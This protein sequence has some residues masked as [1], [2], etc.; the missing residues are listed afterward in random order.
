MNQIPFDASAPSEQARLAFDHLYR[1]V[2]AEREALDRMNQHFN[3]LTQRFPKRVMEQEKAQEL[4]LFARV[5]G[6]RGWGLFQDR[7][8]LKRHL[9]FDAMSD[10]YLQKKRFAERNIAFYV[11]RMGVMAQESIQ[12]TS[13]VENLWRRLEL[14]KRLRPLWEYTANDHLRRDAFAAY[15]RAFR[16]LPPSFQRRAFSDQMT[17]YLFRTA[18]ELKEQVWFHIEAIRLLVDIDTQAF[19]QVAKRWFSD[20]QQPDALF[21][22]ARITQTWGNFLNIYPELQD[23]APMILADPSPFVRQTFARAIIKGPAA[24][25]QPILQ[26]VLR[27]ACPQVQAAALLGFN[28]CLETCPKGW[29][30]TEWLVLFNE[31]QDVWLKRVAL[32]VAGQLAPHLDPPESARLGESLNQA[33][34]GP[35]P[36]PLRRQVAMVL[37]QIWAKTDPQARDLLKILAEWIQTIPSGQRKLLPEAF[38]NQD[39]ELLGRCLS[40]LAQNDYGLDLEFTLRGPALRRGPTF[41]FRFWR[42]WHEFKNTDPAKR[43]GV[44]HTQGRLSTGQMRAPSAIL[45][46]LT[47]AKVPG[48]PLHLPQEGGWRPYLPLVEDFISL[49]DFNLASKPIRFFHAEGITEVRP[50]SS[51]TKRLRAYW[52]L[53]FRYREFAA[54][55]EW[56]LQ[57]GHGPDAYLRAIQSLGFKVHLQALPGKPI[58]G[59]VQR[60]FP[61]FAAAPE[62]WLAFRNYL[63][64]IFGNN[65]NELMW[66]L[67]GMFALFLGKHTWL[68]AR[69]RRARQKIPLVIGGWG[70]RG[71]SGTERLKAA[72]FNGMGYSVFSKT[73]GCEA[74]FVCCQPY[75][76]L[77]EFPLFRPY[78]KATIWEQGDVVHMAKGMGVEVF[79]WECMGLNDDYV[80]ILQ[81]HW[82][83]DDLA[84]LTNAFPDHEDI[85]G[86]AGYNIPMVMTQFIPKHSRLLTTEESMRPILEEAAKKQKTEF[87][88]LGWLEAGLIPPDL[89]A[90]FPYEEHPY[91]IALVAALAE[92]LGVAWDFA[93]KEMADRVVPDLGVLKTFPPAP[94]QTR[95]L[96]FS[97]GM[98]ANE[99]LGC[100][101]N[102]QR[103]GFDRFSYE[104]QPDHF[105]TCVVNNRA[106]R[107]ARSQIFAEL[108]VQDLSVDGF[109]IIGSNLEGMRGY[110]ES[111][112]RHFLDQYSLF[113]SQESPVVRFENLAKHFRVPTHEEPIRQRFQIMLKAFLSDTEIDSFTRHWQDPQKLEELLAH[114]PLSEAQRQ[115][116]LRFH[117]QNL[118]ELQE[119]RAFLGRLQTEKVAT[120]G[121][122]NELHKLVDGWFFHRIHFVHDFHASGNEVIQALIDITPFG[123]RNRCMGIQ[124]IKGTG[125]DFAYRFLAW[126]FCFRTTSALLGEDETQFNQ[127]LDQLMTYT[128]YGLLGLEWMSDILDRVPH[129]PIAQKESFQARL[130]VVQSRFE[131][132]KQTLQA[133]AQHQSPSH[134]FWT[135]VFD[136]MET[137]LDVGDAVRRRKKANRIY[138]DL[139]HFR[140]SRN[141]A[142]AA[143]NALNQR[144]KGGWLMRQAQNM[145]GLLRKNEKKDAGGFHGN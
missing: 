72:L 16:A 38:K 21:V 62:L 57:S 87:R 20:T 48:E 145:L 109:L 75:D 96:I 124:N 58:D 47:P 70:T 66:F 28:D 69:L 52:Q 94:I 119:Y 71:K 136:I 49:L 60:F 44:S 29:L 130:A 6:A 7:R 102:W 92:E 106:D 113:D 129:L 43:V 15:T 5:M 93:L 131:E 139:V 115:Q 61:A 40:L 12:S 142:I 81:R 42:A 132:R 89:L 39:P 84:T 95:T 79:L 135:K 24:W 45:A 63:G 110:L 134:P 107:I 4:I 74:M 85:Q 9:D 25:F 80:Q 22:R 91:N 1:Q 32:K 118:E 14:E 64:T 133:T 65:I 17:H 83:R 90:R 54:Y 11:S 23:M 138:R 56:T 123:M 27:D 116:L 31:S 98:S 120:E 13:E 55:R 26:H 99:R 144:Q 3:T 88:A 100:L 53:A 117:G 50:P 36:T 82:M 108:M 114:S 30:L 77:K 41:G 140:I 143:L 105:V 128:D 141:R 111:A 10:R 125:L 103:L 127:A 76:A 67:G 78:D 112:L 51:V 68:N 46:E 18:M 126:D 97:N 33:R 19:I 8:A 34:L 122:K 104:D 35:L 86:P 137:F 37:E 59:Q 2:Q 121:L 101:S 73:T